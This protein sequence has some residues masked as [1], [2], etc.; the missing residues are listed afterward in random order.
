MLSCL[1]MCNLSSIT[2]DQSAIREYT[3]TMRDGA[4]NFPSPPSVSLEYAAPLVRNG[5]AGAR[6]GALKSVS[7]FFSQA[8]AAGR[9]SN[10][11]AS[12]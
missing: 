8:D 4:G 1:L 12:E 11:C 5:D 2:K 7:R 9:C 10:V 3:G 6:L